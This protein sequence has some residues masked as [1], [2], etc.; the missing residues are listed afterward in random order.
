MLKARNNK[1][2]GELSPYLTLIISYKI[3]KQ[4]LVFRITVSVLIP[5]YNFTL[6]QSLKYQLS[7]VPQMLE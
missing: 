6:G 5:L 4:L 3:E 7:G 1:T 2:F